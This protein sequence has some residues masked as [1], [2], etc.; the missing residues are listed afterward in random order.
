MFTEPKGVRET[1]LGVHTSKTTPRELPTT[2]SAA[3]AEAHVEAVRRARGRVL[4]LRGAVQA[5]E[6]VRLVRD[7]G[8]VRVTQVPLHRLHLRE[9]VMELKAV[10]LPSSCYFR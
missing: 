9:L 6:Q 10:S 5:L 4:R 1:L 2:T 3:A 7:D 8:V